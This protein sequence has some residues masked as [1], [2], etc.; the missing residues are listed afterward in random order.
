MLILFPLL[1]N[2]IFLDSMPLAL[3]ID[4]PFN[5][6][7]ATERRILSVHLQGCQLCFK[8]KNDSKKF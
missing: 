2:V 1:K 4:A 8:Q 6:I 5:N 7:H 3:S